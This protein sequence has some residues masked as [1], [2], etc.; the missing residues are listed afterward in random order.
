MMVSTNSLT[1]LLAFER[2]VSWE[3][4]FLIAGNT[5]TGGTIELPVSHAAKKVYSEEIMAAAELTDYLVAEGAIPGDE[6][7]K[8]QF[9]VARVSKAS[10]ARYY[11]RSLE[12]HA[13]GQDA[14]WFI[15]ND[16]QGA[17]NL[18]HVLPKNPEEKWPQFDDESVRR[19]V[20][21]VGNVVL[22]QASQN[23]DVRNF[24][25]DSKRSLYAR[26]PYVLTS[27][28]AEVDKWT[29]DE[30]DTRQRTLAELAVK[31]WPI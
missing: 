7:F 25:F 11:L 9:E 8:R 12:L 28:V 31:T 19:Y 13:Q 15:P 1:S 17:I 27:H 30:I 5:R 21:R 26:A 4:R 14:P 3:V 10:L 6:E 24:D 29:T 23:V 22:L 16:D 2:F 18:E 20:T